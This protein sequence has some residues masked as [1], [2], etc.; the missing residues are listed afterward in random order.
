MNV[1]VAWAVVMFFLKNIYAMDAD[2]L[3]VKL[4]SAWK[5]LSVYVADHLFIKW[6][7]DPSWLDYIFR[8]SIRAWDFVFVK[9][10]S[11]SVQGF[12]RGDSGISWPLLPN[13]NLNAEVLFI[14]CNIDFFQ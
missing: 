9:A 10:A 14:F 11:G 6:D 3:E 4:S 5:H 1:E 8:S 2:I 7:L 12:S 13:E